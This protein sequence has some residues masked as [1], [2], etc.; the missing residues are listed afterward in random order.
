MALKFLVVVFC[1]FSSVVQTYATDELPIRYVNVNNYDPTSSDYGNPRGCD[2][3]TYEKGFATLAKAAR[4]AQD[5]PATRFLVGPGVYSNETFGIKY[6]P[7]CRL[8]DGTVLES[9][10]GPEKTIIVG[11]SATVGD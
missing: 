5:N 9:M 10:E 6:P 8:M 7:R 1:A 4:Y 11:A 2:G 3:L